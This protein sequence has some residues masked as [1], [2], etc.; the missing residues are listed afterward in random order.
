LTQEQQ[1]LNLATTI[2]QTIKDLPIGGSSGFE[3]VIDFGVNAVFCKEFI[4]P[5]AN[6]TENKRITVTPSTQP[7]GENI[8]LNNYYEPIICT[9]I[10]QSGYLL[11]MAKSPTNQYLN[12]KYKVNIQII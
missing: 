3:Q 11:L 9:A 1:I 5:V 4:I 2:G 10:A 7:T 8:G 6:L 12:G